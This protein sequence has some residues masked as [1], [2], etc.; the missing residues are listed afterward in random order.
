[1]AGLAGRHRIGPQDQTHENAPEAMGAVA[2][3][4]DRTKPCKFYQVVHLAQKLIFLSRF[5]HAGSQRL[6]D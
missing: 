5:P 6:S 2:C 3:P 4:Q 1:M